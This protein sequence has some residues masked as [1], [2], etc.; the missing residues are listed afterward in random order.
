MNDFPSPLKRKN[1][2]G[3]NAMFIRRDDTKT[4]ILVGQRNARG[5]VSPWIVDEQLDVAVAS[6]CPDLNAEHSSF[7]GGIGGANGVSASAGVAVLF[8]AAGVAVQP[9]LGEPLDT[10][11]GAITVEIVGEA[12]LHRSTGGIGIDEEPEAGVGDRVNENTSIN[13]ASSVQDEGINWVISTIH[14]SSTGDRQSCST[15]T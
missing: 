6:G 1:E 7:E 14:S 4:L 15:R 12:S 3:L 2:E 10:V 9:E 11:P 5:G 8:P 13:A